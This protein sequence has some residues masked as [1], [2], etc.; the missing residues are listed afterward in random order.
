VIYIRTLQ[1]MAGQSDREFD[2]AVTKHGVRS[3]EVNL[4]REFSRALHSA[5]TMRHMMGPCRC[6]GCVCKHPNT[7]RP[8]GFRYAVCLDCDAVIEREERALVAI[9]AEE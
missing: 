8:T 3:A 1:E 2:A 9:A 7:E 5:I 4:A 6:D